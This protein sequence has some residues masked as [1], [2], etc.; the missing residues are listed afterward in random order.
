MTFF[1]TSPPL[2]PLPPRLQPPSSC[3][4][5][6]DSSSPLPRRSIILS[7]YSLLS[8][9]FP[10]L[11]LLHISCQGLLSRRSVVACSCLSL[12]L[13][14]V[15][16]LGCLI[17]PLQ[18]VRS[19][20]KFCPSSPSLEVPHRSLE[21]RFP[22][23]PFTFSSSAHHFISIPVVTFHTPFP[24]TYPPP[25]PSQHL[26]SP[27]FHGS[28]SSSCPGF[29][30]HSH[31]HISYFFLPAAANFPPRHNNTSRLP[32]SFFFFF[33]DMDV[34]F[35]SSNFCFLFFFLNISASFSRTHG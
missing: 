20:H 14:L 13:L 12:S 32:S 35:C 17:L 18:Q 5:S 34:L 24:V 22:S 11:R 26:A 33:C 4:P 25:P 21:P 7:L 2:P 6:A 1:K 31:F 9:C 29:F 10:T 23:R 27:L 8:A 30:L 28:V 3:F 16:L 15:L 19:H